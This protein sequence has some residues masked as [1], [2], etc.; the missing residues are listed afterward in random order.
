MAKLKIKK[1][2]PKIRKPRPRTVRDSKA[3]KRLDY[4]TLLAKTKNKKRRNALIEVSENLEVKALSECFLNF[5]MGEIK[6]PKSYIGSI[7]R[8]K[9][10]MRL[11]ASKSQSYKKKRKILKKAGGI[12][13]CLPRFLPFALKVLSKLTK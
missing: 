3:L 4:L 2:K 12:G 1:S 9:N 13:D 7:R 11:L 8:H 6:V 10:D 5:L